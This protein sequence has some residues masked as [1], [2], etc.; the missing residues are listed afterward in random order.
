MCMMMMFCM[1][2]IC[3]SVYSTYIDSPD[4]SS[5][6]PPKEPRRA[7]P[8][9]ELKYVCENVDISMCSHWF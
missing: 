5:Y 8:I 2:K 4:G 9:S 7:R 1:F 3:L 6:L